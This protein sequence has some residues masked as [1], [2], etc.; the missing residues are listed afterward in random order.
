MLLDKKHTIQ[1]L[2]IIVMH[3]CKIINAI[4]LYFKIYKTMEHIII[5]N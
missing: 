4:H 1:Y 5:I 2:K 3:P